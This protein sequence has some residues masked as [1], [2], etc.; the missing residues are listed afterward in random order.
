MVHRPTATV[1]PTAPASAQSALR[2]SVTTSS[3]TPRIAASRTIL[4]VATNPS[5]G[6]DDQLVEISDHAASAAKAASAASAG[7]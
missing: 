7:A 3:R 4:L 1:P 2:A 5:S 6:D